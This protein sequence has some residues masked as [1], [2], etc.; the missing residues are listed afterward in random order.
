[1]FLSP[2]VLMGL[3][4]A[5]L[6]HDAITCETSDASPTLEHIDH[7]IEELRDNCDDDVC[8]ASKLGGKT[9]MCG[10]TVDGFSGEGEAVFMLCAG[11]FD[12]RSG[13]DDYV[14]L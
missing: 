13:M 9:G 4:A 1:M 14:C 12:P 10:D 6:A 3:A 5:V 2:L 11:E 7:L 8:F